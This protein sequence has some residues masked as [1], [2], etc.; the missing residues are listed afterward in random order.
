MSFEEIFDLTAGG[1]TVNITSMIPL[2]SYYARSEYD[3]TRLAKMSFEEI[4]DLTAGWSAFLISMIP[5][6]WYTMR[7]AIHLKVACLTYNIIPV[8]IPTLTQ[9]TI[10][11]LVQ[12]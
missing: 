7:Q 8:D 6:A 2:G 9:V 4:F 3:N 1:H 11:Y 5:F 10:E 12:Q